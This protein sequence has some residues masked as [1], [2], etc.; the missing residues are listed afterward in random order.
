MSKKHLENSVIEEILE[1]QEE[2]DEDDEI[3]YTLFVNEKLVS[4]AKTLLY[5]FLKEIHTAHG[6]KHKG[7]GRKLLAHIEKNAKEHG[8]TTMKTGAI[9]PCNHEAIGFFISMGYEPKP[10]EDDET[11]LLEG[12]KRI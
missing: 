2:S 1:T 5:S 9:D 11:G 7:Y 6:E 4:W 10:I 8:A 12:I 3:V